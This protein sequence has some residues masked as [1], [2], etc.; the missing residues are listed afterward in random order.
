MSGTFPLVFSVT[1]GK[2]GVGKTNLSVNLAL[3]LAQLN[4]ASEQRADKRPTMA[5]LRDSGAIE[6]DADGVLLLHRPSVYF[7][8]EQKPKPWDGELLELDVAKNRHGPTG[9]INLTFYGCN[10]RVTE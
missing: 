10:G 5:D 4:R 6:Q 2:G 7:P 9:N 8:Q 1:S 3:C